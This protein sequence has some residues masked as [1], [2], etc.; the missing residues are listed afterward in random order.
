MEGKHEDKMKGRANM[1]YES[2]YDYLFTLC[3]LSTTYRQILE[4]LI[5]IPMGF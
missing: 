2:Y 1:M 4:Y 3:W 5:L